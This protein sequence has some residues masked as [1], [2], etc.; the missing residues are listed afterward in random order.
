MLRLSN[1]LCGCAFGEEAASCDM[2]HRLFLRPIGR[3]GLSPGRGSGGKAGMHGEKNA[4]Q[5]TPAK[6]ERA[7]GGGA[8][9]CCVCGENGTTALKH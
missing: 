3:A 6:S 9:G 2:S 7:P 4:L 5:T 8:Q 1:R